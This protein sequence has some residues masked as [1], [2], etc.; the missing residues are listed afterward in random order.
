MNDAVT[1]SNVTAMLQAL[2]TQVWVLT[3]VAVALF[4]LTGVLFRFEWVSIRELLKSHGADIARHENRWANYDGGKSM[5]QAIMDSSEAASK[6]VTDA[7]NEHGET[8]STAIL[9]K[10]GKRG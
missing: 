8:I 3:G 10:H 5:A 9:N 6:N 4:G 1:N 7:L 2:Q